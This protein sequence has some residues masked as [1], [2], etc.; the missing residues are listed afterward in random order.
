MKYHMVLECYGK[1]DSLIGTVARIILDPEYPRKVVPMFTTQVP[2]QKPCLNLRYLAQY[3]FVIPFCISVLLH[4]FIPLSYNFV[5]SGTIFAF[6]YF[7]Y[8]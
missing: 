1:E 5:I 6:A 4:L 7:C 8:S 2:F 3:K